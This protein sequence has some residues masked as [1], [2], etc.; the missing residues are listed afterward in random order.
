MQ[1]SAGDNPTPRQS[2]R[3]LNSYR[4]SGFCLFT[5]GPPHPCSSASECGLVIGY[6]CRQ[7]SQTRCDSSGTINFSIASLT[8]PDDPGM[9]KIIVSL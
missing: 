6:F 5:S 8:A 3:R 4:V 9:Q 7:I 2:E 1:G